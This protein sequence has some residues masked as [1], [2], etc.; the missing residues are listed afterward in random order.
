MQK[1][2]VQVVENTIEIYREGSLKIAYSFDSSQEARDFAEELV[3]VIPNY[4]HKVNWWGL[5]SRNVLRDVLTIILITM[6]PLNDT[7][8]YYAQKFA[9]AYKAG[10][11]V[12][13]SEANLEK[14]IPEKDQENILYNIF[15]FW[16]AFE[17]YAEIE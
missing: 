9:E 1:H 2:E 17:Y 3:N 8:F 10:E 16:A 11:K 12:D 6:N 4:S 15:E 14:V 5:I 13:L 7:S